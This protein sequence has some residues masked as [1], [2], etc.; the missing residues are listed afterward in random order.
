MNTYTFHDIFD[1]DSLQK[2]MDSLSTTL[3]VGLRIRGLRGECFTQDSDYCTFCRD[4]IKKSPIGCAQ[5][6][7]FVYRG[8]VFFSGNY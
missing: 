1:A 3:Q 5:I 8:D 7:C 2:L 4:V 6:Q